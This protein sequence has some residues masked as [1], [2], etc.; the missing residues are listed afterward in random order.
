MNLMGNVKA[1]GKTASSMAVTPIFMMNRL[2]AK[3]GANKKKCM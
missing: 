3:E 1:K 2:A